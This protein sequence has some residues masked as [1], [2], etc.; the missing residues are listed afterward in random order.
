MNRAIALLAAAAVTASAQIP[1]SYKDLKYPPLNPV[2]VPKIERFTMANGIRVLL[3][4]DHELPRFSARAYIPG[5]KHLDPADKVGLAAITLDTMRSGGSTSR[6]GE[7]L[8]KELDRLPASVEMGAEDDANSATIACLKENAP[9]ALAILADLLR[10]PALPQ[11]KIDLTRSQI[12]AG[13]ER[14]N[15]DKDGIAYREMARLMFGKSSPY[16]RDEEYAT[17]DAI[18]REDVVAYHKANIQPDH[19]MLG[20]WGDFNPAEMRALIEKNFGSWAKGGR[21]KPPTPPVNLSG[22]ATGIHAVDKSDVTQAAVQLAQLVDMRRDHPDFPAF[23]VMNYVLGGGF[24]SRLFDNIRTKEA[25]AYGTGAGFGA[26]YDHA[27]VWRA[28]VGTENKNVPRAIA[29]LKREIRKMQESEITDA[30]L[31]RAKDTLLKG[32]AFNYDSVGKVIGRQLVY[33][34]YGYP[35]DFLERYNAAFNKVTKADVLRVAKK[36]LDLDRMALLTVGKLAEYKAELASSGSVSE[37]DITIPQPKMA[38]AP[39]ASVESGAKARALLAKARAAHGG[40]ALGKVSSYSTKMDMTMVTPQGEFNLKGEGLVSLAGKSRAEMA[41]PMG[42][43]VQVFDGNTVWMKTPQGV[44]QLPPQASQDAKTTALRETIALLRQWDQP[45]YTV[46]ALGTSKLDGKDVEGVLVA[47]ESARL[48]VKLFVDPSTGL[49]A[50]KGYQAQ[51]QETVEQLSDLRDVEG[52]KVPF[53]SVRMTGGKRTQELKIQE[54][55]IN[56]GA[57]DSAFAKPE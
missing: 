39:P 2:K 56:P 3:V 48:Q 19:M 40:A 4:E 47:N 26:Q 22:Q 18:K 29:S 42:Q 50:G 28:T 34:Y 14:R 13:I 21:P 30:E 38:A 43:V 15:D 23:S 1:K 32:D 5:G 37:I 54:F 31:S 20:V 55:K 10:D 24:G 33:E 52:I 41:S 16:A 53:R 7:A 25:L 51:G 6:A 9:K 12:R 44:Q 17:L 45:G 57:P 35:T 11:D 46:Q 49:L 36:Y 8:D 27:G